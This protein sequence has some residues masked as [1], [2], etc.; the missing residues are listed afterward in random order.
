MGRFRSNFLVRKTTSPTHLTDLLY[1][2][3][4]F[5]HEIKA[6]KTHPMDM[7]AMYHA[8]HYASLGYKMYSSFYVNA[9]NNG[10]NKK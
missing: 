9:R 6:T 3:F 5:L 2:M 10:K 1:F 8:D 4:D 7:M